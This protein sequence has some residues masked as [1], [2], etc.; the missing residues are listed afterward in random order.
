MSDSRSFSQSELATYL[1]CQQKHRYEYKRGV[2]PEQ[3][4]TALEFG[5]ALHETIDKTCKEARTA[6][7]LSDEEIQDLATEI[8]PREW[9]S[10]VSRDSYQ[11]DSHYQDDK[12]KAKT[13]ID[14]FFG[15]GPGVDHTRRSVATEEYVEFERNGV[16]YGGHIDNILKTDDGLELVD[17]KKSD[18]SPPVTSQGNYIEEHHND[19][20]RPQRVKHAIQAELYIEGVKESEYYMAGDVVEFTFQ[21][22][23]DDLSIVRK[24]STVRADPDFKSRSVAEDIQANREILWE[25]IEDIVA[26]I[27]NSRHEPVPFR[28]IRD[29]HCDTCPYQSMCSIYLTNEEY[30]L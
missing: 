27:R 16:R 18:I 8:F 4:T 25:L 11:T 5:R 6:S 9:E 7:E 30:K 2:D 14:Q 23:A 15:Q 12:R 19:G 26:G 22:V 10:E 21:A 3:D 1:K 24:G 17:Y 13:A 29:E 28:E 20:Y